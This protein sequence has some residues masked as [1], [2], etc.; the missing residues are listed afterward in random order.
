MF[1][2]QETVETFDAR[3][4]DNNYVATYFPDVVLEDDINGIHINLPASIAALKALGYK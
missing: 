1:I 3:A 4:I 2:V